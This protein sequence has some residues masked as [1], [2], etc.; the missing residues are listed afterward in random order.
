MLGID[1]DHNEIA[2]LPAS[3]LWIHHR[4]AKIE[5]SLRVALREPHADADRYQSI[6]YAGPV[7]RHSVGSEIA[8]G[9]EVA[10]WP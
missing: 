5:G 2:P 7:L 1:F 10:A 9:D 6:V 8:T 4:C 3:A